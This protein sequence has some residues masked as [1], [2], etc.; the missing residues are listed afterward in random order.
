MAKGLKV[1]P[2]GLKKV[3]K[4]RHSE[5]VAFKAGWCQEM[6]HTPSGWVGGRKFLLPK[7]PPCQPAGDKWPKK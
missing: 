3:E 6:V 1:V 5:K 2:V 4:G 7:C